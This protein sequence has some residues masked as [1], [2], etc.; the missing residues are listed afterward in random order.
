MTLGRALW[1]VC[2][3]ALLAL[4]VAV[5][6][7]AA[8]APAQTPQPCFGDM[9][10]AGVKAL[11]GPRVRFGLTPA[12]VAGALGPPVPVTPLS[13]PKTLAALRKLKAPGKP[14]VLRLNRF[15]WSERRAGFRKFLRRARGYAHEG[16]LVE[17]QLR[18]HPDERQEGDIPRWLR[19]VRN[20][21]R[22]FGRSERIIAIQVANEVN[23]TISPD[24]S[25]GAYDGARAA[26]VRGVIAAKAMARRLGYDHLTIGFNWFYR[27]DPQ[28]EASFWAYLRDEGGV[29]FRRSVD[30]V[31]LDTYP[32]TV[33]PPV[34]YPGGE[35][36]GMV[37]AMSTLRKCFMP[38]AGLGND[39]PIHIEENGWP[40]GP[41]R[42][43]A[44]QE[45]AMRAM[46]GAVHE[47]RGTYNVSDYRWFNLRDHNSSGP[48]FQQYYGLLRDDYTPKPA[49]A[50]YREL[51]RR[52]A[53]G[54]RG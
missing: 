53:R 13:K 44:Q 35:R 5:S 1:S 34:E 41:G 22:A 50:A 14:L 42:T 11:P 23:F 31:G 48:N 32:G 19:W 2:A 52:L 10:A 27:T 28:N 54:H 43:E 37:A 16:Y 6:L 45:I 29:R 12:G 15:F 33:F 4:L 46:V 26:L 20:V 21:V 30:W 49:F 3:T 9:S 38:I 39:V 17:L 36:D 7:P 51:I 25:D 8:P 18:Y 40:T 47:F 24:S